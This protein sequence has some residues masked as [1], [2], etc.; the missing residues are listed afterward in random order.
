MFVVYN[1]KTTR[2]LKNH[3]GVQTDKHLF[4]TMGAAKAA[5]TRA[6]KKTAQKVQPILRDDFAIAESSVFHSTIEKSETVKNLMSGKLVE[7]R[8][9]TLLAC[10]PSRETYWSI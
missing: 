1:T 5:L 3:P 10:D 9:N 4:E 6:V 7:Q 8:V 2:Y